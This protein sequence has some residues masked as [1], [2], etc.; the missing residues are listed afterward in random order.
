VLV[1]WGEREPGAT[2]QA[3][4]Q[5]FLSKEWGNKVKCFLCPNVNSEALKRSQETSIFVE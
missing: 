3:S 2:G 1:V 5:K 4:L